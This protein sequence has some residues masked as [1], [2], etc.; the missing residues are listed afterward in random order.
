[1]AP[2]LKQQAAE[3][4]KTDAPRPTEAES[5]L[6]S[7][8][9]QPHAEDVLLFSVPVCA[10]Y[11]AMTSY[12]YKVKLTP[13]TQKKGKAAKMALNSFLHSRE[14]LAREKDLLRSV[15]DTDLSRNMPGK[16]KV[17]APNLLNTKK[18]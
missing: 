2:S 14:S 4:S 3:G 13:G 12:K 18:K 15:K 9:A 5:L 10:P 8:T 1:M 16:V 6:D 11:T 7:L 17:S